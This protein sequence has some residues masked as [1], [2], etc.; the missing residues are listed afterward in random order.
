MERG[1]LELMQALDNQIERE[2]GR[3]TP[4]ELE[5]HGVQKW[6]PYQRRIENLVSLILNNLGDEFVKIDSILVLAQ[7]FPKALQMIAADLGAEGLGKMRANYCSSAFESIG[8]DVNTGIQLLKGGA[9][10]N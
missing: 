9:D 3:R 6:E 7:A 4:S 1:L 8:R 10:L 2:V 5:E